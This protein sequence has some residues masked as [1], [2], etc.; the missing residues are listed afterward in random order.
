[1]FSESKKLLAIV[2]YIV[3]VNLLTFGVALAS[4]K[5]STLTDLIVLNGM[6]IWVMTVLPCCTNGLRVW[7]IIL[8]GLG[9]TII[10]SVIYSYV[11]F[12]ALRYTLD[13]VSNGNGQSIML[14]CG[15]FAVSVLLSW[16]I[17]RRV[18]WSEFNVIKCGK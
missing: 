17:T 12:I 15:Y 8:L 7:K 10:W 9:V 3:L 16:V 4:G 13:D 18:V 5:A 6:I 14:A 2:F 1:M 11:T